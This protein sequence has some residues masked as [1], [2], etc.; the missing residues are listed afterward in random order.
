MKGMKDYF[1]QNTTN[2]GNVMYL[3]FVEAGI[4]P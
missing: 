1:V 2:V 3:T 4:I